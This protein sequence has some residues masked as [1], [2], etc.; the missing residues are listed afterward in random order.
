[1]IIPITINFVRRRRILILAFIL[2]FIF[3]GTFHRHYS[4]PPKT[5]EDLVSSYCNAPHQV[6]G[7]ETESIHN[8]RLVQLQ[9]LIRHGDRAPINIKALPNT[10]PVHL[11]CRFHHQNHQFNEM[12]VKYKHMVDRGVF[13]VI[14][15]L[16]KEL[17]ENRNQ[18]YGGQLTIHG[19][20]QHLFI[21]NHLKNSYS[22]FSGE[23][24][25][26]D[27]HVISTDTPRTKQSAAAFLTG[28]FHESFTSKDETKI[29]L[30]VHADH[31]NAHLCL[32]KD[33]KPLSCP[34]LAKKF[35][36][37]M[38]GPKSQ[39]FDKNIQPV[40]KSIAYYLSSEVGEFT[41]FNEIVDT[42][43][44]RACHG[45]GVPVGPKYTLP[46][47]LIEQT[48][49]YAHRYSTIRHSGELA[50]LQ[51][52]SILSQIAKQI[53]N[54]VKNEN[55]NKKLILYSG[56]DSMIH[57]FLQILNDKFKTW[58]PYASRIVFEVY[59]ETNTSPNDKSLYSKTYFRVLYNGEA[60]ENIKF[61]GDGKGPMKLYSLSHVMSYLTQRSFQEVKYY[62]SKILN[63]LLFTKIESLCSR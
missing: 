41:R 58:P 48:F 26:K 52:L 6:T 53:I 33:E 1:M 42:F 31:L 16:H 4:G 15:S 55:G 7:D 14:G 47:S 29:T 40:L 24:L 28:M 37:V 59:V 11:S 9:I 13:K 44:T 49:G 12:L 21:G 32:D 17:I 61:I 22:K 2:I 25:G 19:I 30:N 45:L 43:Y 60:L 56:H 23:I 34:S 3:L 5:F 46:L 18:C 63:E 38:K 8:L 62:E 20:L 39:A 35:H 54:V 36:Q 51:T 57:P 50:E 10:S 27:I